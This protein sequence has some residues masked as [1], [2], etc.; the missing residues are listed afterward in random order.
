MYDAPPI[1]PTSTAVTKPAS[2]FDGL[3]EQLL[4]V[5]FQFLNFE[6]ALYRT[7]QKSIHSIQ[8]VWIPFLHPL[9]LFFAIRHHDFRLFGKSTFA[10]ILL[11]APILFLLPLFSFLEWFEEL[12]DVFF[13]FFRRRSFSEQM[14]NNV[15]SRR[16]SRATVHLEN[17]NGVENM[18]FTDAIHLSP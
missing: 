12:D 2:S 17:S 14:G 10:S 11:I 5:S 15:P 9:P 4:A 8:S 7:V 18:S 13:S 1:R 3:L 6:S 16:M